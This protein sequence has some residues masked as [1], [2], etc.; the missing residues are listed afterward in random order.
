MG[1]RANIYLVDTDDAT[2]GI[3][4]Y[5]HWS[6]ED[7]PERLRRALAAGKG[8]WGDSQYL[9]RIIASRVFMDIHNDETGGGISTKMGDNSVGCSILICD[10]EESVV[11]E[12][13]EGSEGDRDAWVGA[14]SF[15]DFVASSPAAWSN[16]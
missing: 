15:A 9:A 8:R 13:P 12:A 6:G 10:L 11:A 2:H 4:L 1:D 14:K 16:A 7:W 3:Y 5:T